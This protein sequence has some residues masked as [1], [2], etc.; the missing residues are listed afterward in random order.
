MFTEYL[1]DA[2]GRRVESTL[3]RRLTEC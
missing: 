2:A 3:A 1:Y